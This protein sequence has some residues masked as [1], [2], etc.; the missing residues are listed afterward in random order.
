MSVP[1]PLKSKRALAPK[2][3]ANAAPSRYGPS[4][5]W[6]EDPNKSRFGGAP[7][8]PAGT[9]SLTARLLRQ[10]GSIYQIQLSLTAP[11]GQ[12]ISGPV[13][14]HLHP[15]FSNPVQEVPVTNPLEVTLEI[16]AY[17]AFTVGVE[18]DNGQTRLELDLA[19]APDLPVAFRAA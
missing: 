5:S 10:T 9:R 12:P 11:T 16:S 7:T 1:P 4:V 19:E 17:G 18:A 6:N 8:D 2:A 15:T 13:V 3:T 14:F